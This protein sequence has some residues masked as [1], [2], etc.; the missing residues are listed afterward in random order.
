MTA[1]LRHDFRVEEVRAIHD[2]ALP[3]LLFRAQQVHRQHHRPE[4]VQLCRAAFG[5]DRRV[6]GRLCLLCP[7]DTLLDGGAA[8]RAC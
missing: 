4:E 3:E 5:E 7:V 6:P 1:E 8:G 2:L